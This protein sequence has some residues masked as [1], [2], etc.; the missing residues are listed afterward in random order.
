M[1]CSALLIAAAFLAYGSTSVAQ[2]QRMSVAAS[3]LR[4]TDQPFIDA[5]P[6]LVTRK[7]TTL[8]FKNGETLTDEGDCGEGD[9]TQYRVDGVWRGQFVGVDVTQY[10]DSDYLLVNLDANNS[11][12]FIGSRPIP[13]PDGKLFFAGFHDDRKWSPYQ[14]ASV[15][16]LDENVGPN[17]LRVVDTQLVAFDSFTAWRGNQCVEF[18]GSRGYNRGIQPTRV[19]WL[20]R[21]EGDW[22]LLE[23]PSAICR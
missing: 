17:R 2:D 11:L 1:N 22:Q 7:G 3:A 15:W 9:C 12:E 16:E 6:G 4:D 14:G 23:R 19:F 18:K 8:V 10:E 20:A 13:S 21:Q 5:H